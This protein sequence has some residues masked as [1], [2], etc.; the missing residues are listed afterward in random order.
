MK[1]N[2]LEELQYFLIDNWNEITND[3]FASIIKGAFNALPLFRRDTAEAEIEYMNRFVA[4]RQTTYGTELTGEFNIK[5]L[6]R[7][8]GSKLEGLTNITF[9]I[10]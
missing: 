4:N 3:E 10:N 5:D 7:A 6:F 8:D 2:T 1:I 9:T